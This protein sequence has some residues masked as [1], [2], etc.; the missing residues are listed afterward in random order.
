MNTPLTPVGSYTIF[1]D[2]DQIRK[3]LDDAGLQDYQAV[4]VADFET[5]RHHP[6]FQILVTGK[7]IDEDPSYARPSDPDGWVNRFEAAMRKAGIE[8]SVVVG[9]VPR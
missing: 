3:A 1:A 9:G 7:T 8:I 4:Y 5:H 2:A 6:V